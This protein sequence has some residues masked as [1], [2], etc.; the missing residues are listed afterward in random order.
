MLPFAMLQWKTNNSFTMSVFILPPPHFPFLN[1]PSLIATKME[2]LE[3]ST[4]LSLSA[5]LH[6]REISSFDNVCRHR[7]PLALHWPS[8][9]IL[10]AVAVA[11]TVLCHWPSTT[12]WFRNS[13][14]RQLFSSIRVRIL[15]ISYPSNR[16]FRLDLGG[17]KMVFLSLVT[18]TVLKWNV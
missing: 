10:L 11:G 5:F 12:Q 13:D 8:I 1:H 2:S 15:G 16:A 7:H 4:N 3:W 17:P 9:V 14:S 6:P 18:M